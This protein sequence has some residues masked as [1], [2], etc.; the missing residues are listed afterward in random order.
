MTGEPDDFGLSPVQTLAHVA[1]GQKPHGYT[2]F[3]QQWRKDESLRTVS[4]KPAG[5]DGFGDPGVTHRLSGQDEAIGCRLIEPPE[6]TALTGGV[7]IG[8]G[9]G[10]QKSLEEEA[11]GFG[12]LTARGLA[13]LVIRVRGFA[14]SPGGDEPD[15]WILKGLAD[16]A[17]AGKEPDPE[18]WIVSGAVRDTVNA[19]RA[20]AAWL[21]ER[22]V[23]TPPS[24]HGVS[25]A[26]GLATI[27]AAQLHRMSDEGFEGC[28][29][30]RLVLGAPTFGDWPW[31]MQSRAHS[32]NGSGA[33]LWDLFLRHTRRADELLEMLRTYD[34]ALHARDVR[35]P[36]LCRLAEK[37][38]VVPAPTAAAVFNA[39]ATDTG[40]KWRFVTKFG[41][42]D[43]GLAHA[44]RYELFARCSAD[45]LDPARDPDESMP[46]WAGV[47]AG[48]HTGPRGQDPIGASG[49]QERLFADTGSWSDAEDERLIHA[50]E[51]AGRTLDDL[52]YTLEF[53]KLLAEADAAARGRTGREVLSR[54][55]NMR[56]AG[57]LPK[58]G[59]A[60][61]SPVRVDPEEEAKLSDM[62]VEAAG[63][64]GQRDRLPYTDGF[65][66]I[67]ERFNAETGRSLS[68]HEL[69]RL[70]ARLAK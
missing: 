67:V 29:L 60:P 42:Y 22:G 65:D 47:M 36:V 70:V 7:V 32:G 30:S 35:C 39:L 4:L 16:R 19:V 18:A 52:P 57:R 44:R 61:A 38:D 63:G 56:K 58:L 41:H 31:R 64:L 23:D 51:S 59:R 69:W 11:S 37:D 40:R 62:V 21:R 53:E 28:G 5:E 54:L 66:R 27:A 50:Y 17:D 14:G 55:L 34:A 68:P 26:G 49:P 20:L 45:F 8:H 46:E 48:V 12:K 9:Y 25:L 3:W 6:G 2:S 24:L 43:G 10:P 15:G 13:V 1:G 33:E